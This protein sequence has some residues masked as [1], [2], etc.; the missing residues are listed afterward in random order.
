MMNVDQRQKLNPEALKAAI[1]E[2]SK[3]K[4]RRFLPYLVFDWIGIIS[5]FSIFAFHHSAVNFVLGSIVLGLS[6]HGLVVL[7]HE[8]VHYR[9]SRN[10]SLN[11]WIGRI[12]CFFP[13]GITVSSYRDFHFP[14]HRDPFGPNDPEIPLRKALGANFAPEFTVRRG[15]RLWALSFLGGSLKEAGIF[16][17]MLPLGMVKEKIYLLVY[18]TLLLGLA[19]RVHAFSYLGMWVYGMV[20]T[21]FSMLRIQGW[22]EHGLSDMATNRYALP[23]PIYR[24]MMPHNIWVHYEHHKYP[25]VPFFNL[26]KVRELD[27]SDKIY[28]IEEMVEALS[29]EKY[30]NRAA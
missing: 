26:E 15:L 11:E 14:H 9:I 22:Y 4:L 8:A 6:Q 16:S 2:L 19:Y 17:A 29:A 10:K 20:T 30:L 13:I 3:P 1:D 23:S 5:G 18:W 12:A 25:S 24:L 21:Y 28:S 27:S 7:G